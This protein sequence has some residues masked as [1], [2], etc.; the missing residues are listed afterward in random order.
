MYK[1]NSNR[2]L[3]VSL[4]IPTHLLVCWSILKTYLPVCQSIYPS[5]YLPVCL[6]ILKTYLPSCL[7]V[8]LPVYWLVNPVCLSIYLPSYLSIVSDC[9]SACL[10]ICV[11][12]CLRCSDC[13]Q[14]YDFL[15][16]QRLSRWVFESL[17]SKNKNIFNLIKKNAYE[18]GLKCDS[19]WTFT[20]AHSLCDTQL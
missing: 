13:Q 14:K 2:Y 20:D 1:K 19:N 4:S 12:A 15:Q 3:S 5:N 8:Y 17:D 9:V 18:S 10:S 16:I 6:S 7:F 11:S